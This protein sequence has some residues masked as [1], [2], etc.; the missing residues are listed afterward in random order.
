MSPFSSGLRKA[1]GDDVKDKTDAPTPPLP[2]S[3]EFYDEP[4]SDFAR[5]QAEKHKKLGDDYPQRK[6]ARQKQEAA[7]MKL[8]AN[9]RA[10]MKADRAK[11]EDLK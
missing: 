9:A 2:S 4:N 3:Q 5:R 8:D 11:K 6:E 10:K 7:A 1:G